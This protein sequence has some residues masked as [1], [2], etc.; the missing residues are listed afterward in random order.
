MK[1]TDGK[2]AERP[3]RASSSRERT[4]R[5]LQVED[6]GSRRP[7][8][9]GI[10]V[11]S[12]MARGIP[13][14][15]AFRAADAVRDRY[16]PVGVVQKVQIRKDLR[17]I[18]GEDPF[19]DD[20]SLVPAPASITVMGAGKGAPFSKGLL[21]QSLLAAA[22]EPNDAFD[23]AR[24]I[25]RDLLLRGVRKVARSDLRRITF[26]T[27]RERSSERAAERYL[28][29]RQHQDPD[30]PVIILLGGAAGVGKTSLAIEVAHR[31][32]IA[33]VLSSDSIR[34]VMRIMLSQD[35]MPTLHASSYD[36]YKLLPAEA[37]GDDPV[38]E[39]YLSQAA[40]VSVG[41]RASLDRAIAENANLVLDGVSVAP[42]LID[43]DSYV[44][45][46]D[47]IFLLVSALDEES[48]VNR[49][50]T[51]GSSA[52]DRPPHRYMENLDSILAIQNH[53]LELA[54][55]Y[56]VPIVDNVSFD[57]SVLQIIRHVTE[58]LRKKSRSDVAESP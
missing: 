18:L 28:V 46:A 36:A 25:E 38:I 3:S 24:A 9:R 48:F 8:M 4:D 19:Q 10:V 30:R 1:P 22:L 13:F 14:E 44:D 6:S 26:E 7:F 20:E 58:S 40:T 21:S 35:L 2:M 49:F 12:L 51:R 23:V 37:Q 50:E 31:M 55:R 29:W 45:R 11:H 17:E 52:M 54:D 15:D 41:I 16:R 42:G 43:L 57:S 39:G 5:R 53:L 33:R 34:Q 27:L 47:V 56:D 32:G